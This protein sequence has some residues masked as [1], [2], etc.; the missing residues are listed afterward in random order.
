MK[1][2]DFGHQTSVCYVLT[3]PVV[4]RRGPVGSTFNVRRS[5]VVRDARVIDNFLFQVDYYLDLQNVVEEDLKIKTAAML[6][7]G[8]AVAWWRRKMLDIENGECTI[9]T[10]DE[11]RKQLK[12]Y[13]MPV[14][15]ERHAYRLVANLKQIGALRDYIR[16]YQKVMLVVPM[17]PE[18]DKLHWFIIGLRSWAQADVERS[19]PETL[20]QAYVAA[21]RLADTQRKS[22]TDTFKAAKKSDHDGKRDDRRDHNRNEAVSQKPTERKTF[23][24]KN[25]TGPP[26]EVTCWVY[27][28][29]HQACVCPKRVRPTGG[30]VSGIEVCATTEN[31]KTVNSEARHILREAKGV[32]VQIQGWT[33]VTNFSVVPLDDFKV[34]L[35][36]KFLQGQNAMI[37]P[38]TNTLTLMG[39]NQSHTVHCHSIRGKSQPTLSAMQLK[40]GVHHGEQTFLVLPL[41]TIG[42]AD[43]RFKHSEDDKHHHCLGFSDASYEV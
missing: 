28:G 17:M 10:F 26:R 7:D 27:G 39:A 34:I 24:R 23:F 15:A 38:K 8:D 18:K 2:L 30:G 5:T 29:K 35:G 32:T 20:E 43:S 14:D 12:G 6:L 37:L 25:Y 11:F 13:F 33:G 41:H 3:R 1:L 22:Y 21:E 31:L 40:K 9:T 19:N 16:A 4:A 36:M 42:F